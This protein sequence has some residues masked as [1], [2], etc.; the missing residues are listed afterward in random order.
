MTLLMRRQIN[1][2]F[3]GFSSLPGG[4]VAGEGCPDLLLSNPWFLNG[5]AESCH[6]ETAAIQWPSRLHDPLACTTC[7]T[8]ITMGAK[9]QE[10]RVAAMWLLRLSSSGIATRQLGLFNQQFLTSPS[11]CHHHA[12]PQCATI[13]SLAFAAALLKDRLFNQLCS[14]AFKA[15]NPFFSRIS[16]RLIN[17]KNSNGEEK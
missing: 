11:H 9:T 8:C 14:L 6:V 4:S 17:C 7:I 3:Q 5:V 2:W 12:P 10:R 1:A 15:V 13:T 16:K